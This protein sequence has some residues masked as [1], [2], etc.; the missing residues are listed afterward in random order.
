MGCGHPHE[1]PCTQVLSMMY[2]FIDDEIDEV[3][4][5]QVT[6]HLAECSP[7]EG[8]FTAQISIHARIQRSC[9]ATDQA[10]VNLRSQ[11]ISQIR[12]GMPPVQ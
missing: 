4:R 5:I 10:P 7:C 3:G 6:T 8:E 2:I 12:R 11:I 9:R 1:V